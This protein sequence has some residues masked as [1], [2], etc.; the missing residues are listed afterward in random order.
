MSLITFLAALPILWLV[1]ELVFI[2][3]KNSTLNASV[4][5]L[6]LTVIL[7][8]FIWKMSIK[9]VATAGFEGM[10]MS[11]WPISTVILSAIF[12][13]NVCDYSGNIKYIRNALSS[14]SSD[15]R[16]LVLIVAW[17]FGNFIEG[18]AGFGTSVAIVTSMLIALGFTP[19]TSAVIALSAN[20]ISS[21]FGSMGVQMPTLSR[22]TGISS[23]D[24]AIASVYVVMPMILVTP[25]VLVYITGKAYNLKPI[26]GG[27]WSLIIVSAV[28]FMVAMY[29]MVKYVNQDLA[30][31]VGAIFSLIAM[32]I[33]IKL[34]NKKNHITSLLNSNGSLKKQL[35][36]WSPFIICIILL[37]I[38]SKLFFPIYNLLSYVKISIPIPMENQS[39]VYSME[40]LANA[41][42]WILLS[43][44]IG[45]ILQGLTFRQCLKVLTNSFVQIW[46]TVVTL[47]ILLA[48]SRI[49][50]HSGM[51]KEIALS[52]V[53]FFGYYY[54]FIVPFIGSIGAFITGSATSANVLLGSLQV[55]AATELKID[56]SI[57]MG[58]SIVGGTF[59]K[60]IS[61][62]NIAIGLSSAKLTG[63]EGGMFRTLLKWYAFYMSVLI[64]VSIVINL[65][66][67]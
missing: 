13:Y 42:V 66:F 8:I 35:V 64:E 65:F 10:I 55:T 53:D 33:V 39:S 6:G 12:L 54:F 43:S 28:S 46:R 40:L 63:K 60:M 22:V 50:T 32:L 52:L 27:I 23:N 20:P 51:I 3:R 5:T 2:K 30:G 7:A 16:V 1:I 4:R 62:Q 41:T 24:L 56:S 58:F 17:G 57:L 38:T 26:F 21:V 18:V 9:N 47:M 59:G 36:A 11:L 67:V 31:V 19:F 34:L 25:F 15:K 48:I 29:V 49:M 45:G 61:P 44:F 14:K 37:T